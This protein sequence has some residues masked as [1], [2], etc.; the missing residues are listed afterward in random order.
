MTDRSP[1]A[2]QV[3][4]CAVLVGVCTGLIEAAYITGHWYI[5]PMIQLQSWDVLWMAPLA[6]ACA[7]GL[8]GVLLA[9]IARLLG[10]RVTASWWILALLLAAG[11]ELFLLTFDQI[12]WVT[13]LVAAAGVGV[14]GARLLASRIG[15]IW[16][17]AGRWA[18]R[19]SGAIALVAIVIHLGGAWR[20]RRERAGLPPA[21]AGMPNIL[22]LVLDTTRR[23][24]LHTYGYG[25]ATSPHI[26]SLAAR[27]MT[28]EHAISAASWTLPS[29]AAM[30]TGHLPHDITATWRVP[31][32]NQL[33]TLAEVLG[34]QGYQS[35]GFVGNTVYISRE[36]GLARGFQRF[37]DF[38]ISL[39]KILLTPA[40]GR[41]WILD[42]SERWRMVRNNSAQIN[43]WCLDW[44]DARDPE[45]PFF[46]FLNYADAHDPY[47]PPAPFDRQF[48]D[49]S[50]SG[51]ALRRRVQQ[52]PPQ[53]WLPSDLAPGITQ[54]DGAIAYM[55]AE[56]GTLLA[57]LE[58]RGLLEHTI[59]IVTADHGEQLGEHDLML[60]GN[61][62]Y[63]PLLEVPLIIAGPGVTVGRPVHPVSLVD[64]AATIVSLS[65]ATG[66]AVLPGASLLGPDAGGRSELFSELDYMPHLANR[67]G[68]LQKGPMW[69]VLAD[70][71]HLIR[72]G[73]AEEEMYEFARDTLE[74]RDRAADSAVAP[75]R[76]HLGAR[77]DSLS[78]P[79]R[80]RNQGMLPIKERIP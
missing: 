51:D 27:G 50:R 12:Y 22:L 3:V 30:F 49:S 31:L 63:R 59:V 15:P 10:G 75:L 65:G 46:A 78:A 35:G 37:R 60:H 68:P 5:D 61:S 64:L 6:D 52:L 80:I 48:G 20:E 17:G 77:L 18:V 28:F 7:I 8:V 13:T 72:R 76:R 11:T 58:R 47:E 19:L 1:T 70:D 55:D 40:F 4:A 67:K 71:H 41:R 42:W 29:H 34:R 62:L 54:Y 45:R 24:H 43:Q 66:P 26:D 36:T 25:R 73:D 74:A 44:L 57:G 56:L 32:G 69:S 33:P 79:A 2:A 38:R 16:S 21:P 39:G 53:R 14:Q 23:D 9:L